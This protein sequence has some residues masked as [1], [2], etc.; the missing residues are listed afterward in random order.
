MLRE[1][2][3]AVAAAVVVAL[4][5]AALSVCYAMAPPGYGYILAGVPA[6]AWLAAGAIL[7]VGA[8]LGWRSKSFVAVRALFMISVAVGLVWTFG[9]GPSAAAACWH[10]HYVPGD[11]VHWCPPPPRE[12]FCRAVFPGLNHATEDDDRASCA[13]FWSRLP[14]CPSD[15]TPVAPRPWFL[16]RD[17]NWDEHRYFRER[18]YP[19][20]PCRMAASIP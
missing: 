19:N 12:V 2:G 6:V 11:R 7:L 1:A 17:R 15:E 3:K 18:R 20:L 14:V 10:S 4:C 9:A 16:V 5:Y 13:K 8:R